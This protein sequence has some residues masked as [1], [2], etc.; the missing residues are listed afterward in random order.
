MTAEELEG[1]HIASVR[2]KQSDFRNRNRQ[3]LNLKVIF[4]MYIT[5]YNYAVSVKFT[6]AFIA[7][8][9]WFFDLS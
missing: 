9:F 2:R 8:L 6:Q 4:L 7:P 5:M 1:M 3:T